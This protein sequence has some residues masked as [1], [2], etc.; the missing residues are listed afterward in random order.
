M[1]AHLLAACFALAACL[2]CGGGGGGG[3][4]G[5]SDAALATLSPSAG[6]LSPR[7][8]PGLY[9]YQLTL[10]EGV[11]TFRL[12]PTARNPAVRSITVAVDAG[13]AVPVASG[14]ATAPLPAPVVGGREIVTLTV[15][16]ELGTVQVYTLTVVRPSTVCATSAP[17]LV[18]DPAFSVAPS[19]PA[20]CATV[21]AAYAVD[22]ATG[23]P[24]FDQTGSAPDTARIQ[25]AIGGCAAGAVKLAVDPHDA[26]HTAFLSGPLV[27]KSNVV[28]LVD[29]GVTLFASRNPADYDKGAGDCGHSTTTSSG[30]KPFISAQGT[31]ASSPIVNAGIMGTGTIDG[32]GGEPM[33]GGY[34]TDPDASW[35]DYANA[36]GGTFSNPRLVDVGYA[37]NFT[38][39]QITLQNSPKFHV[40]L[41]SDGFMVWGVTIH[42]P[43]RATNSVGRV[44]S[45]AKARNTDGIDPYNA[46]DGSIVFSTISTGDDQIALKCGEANPAG[47]TASCHDITIAHNH[48]GTGHGMSIGSETNGGKSDGT[49]VGLDGLHVYD[50]SIDGLVPNG[51]AG[52][53]NLNGLRIKS[54]RSRGGIVRNVRYEDVCMRGLANPI[55]LNPNYDSSAS[56]TAYPTFAG[57]TMKNVRH[58][59]CS[60]NAPVPAPVVTL[61]GYDATHLSTVTLDGVVVDG[62]AAANVKA[63]Y[64]T[65][66][67]GPGSVNVPLS[68]ASGTGVTVTDQRSAVTAPNACAGKF[69]AR[70]AA[71]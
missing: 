65:V 55:L 41:E 33:V 36:T 67:L 20:V 9:T 5:S 10:D 70:P 69:V 32:L 31:S 11:D 28:L 16:A 22:A 68:S 63:Q 13:A 6:A 40:G 60:G 54:D 62:I 52:N 37:K 3:S 56:G 25:A 19:V 27:L 43:S 4:G 23:L 58:V 66:T 49:G 44:L 46:N 26:T 64:A 51:G 47:A 42:T 30:C 21:T 71:R 35:W 34:G 14:A 15:T 17:V 59:D 7:F 53:V 48:F 39:Y 18:S 29:E 2:A 12:T 50:L 8:A 38:L 24:V 61:N 45:P 57:V 1:R